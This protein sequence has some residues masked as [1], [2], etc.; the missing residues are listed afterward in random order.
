M[1]Y[2]VPYTRQIQL[3]HENITAFFRERFYYHLILL[4]YIFVAQFLLICVNYFSHK[5][6]LKQK[7]RNKIIQKN[8]SKTCFCIPRSIVMCDHQH[9]Y[10]SLGS[11]KQLVEQFQLQFYPCRNGLPI[12]S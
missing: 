12:L 8:C 6:I 9:A 3:K 10:N 4:G 2:R 1:N 5:P 7:S 11:R